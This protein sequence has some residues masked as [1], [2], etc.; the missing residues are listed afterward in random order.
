[1]TMDL[2]LID[3]HELIRSGLRRTFEAQDDMT[4][5]AELSTCAQARAAVWTGPALVTVV[6]VNLPDGSG[7][8]LVPQLRELA[9]NMGIVVL[10]MLDSDEH[11]LRAL[12]GGASAFVTKS[13]ASCE[14]VAA[15]RHA[16]ASPH[17]FTAA[18][19]AGAMRRRMAAGRGVTL[20]AR[21]RDVLDLLKLGIPVSSVAARLCISSSTAKAHISKVYEK[22]GVENRTQAIMEA[23]RLGLL[24]S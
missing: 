3:D 15:V 19:L 16:A 14:L 1:M 23:L 20:T 11:L 12:D 6:D 24:A 7:L 22:L 9:P 4:V 17:A 18:D 10:T 2:V 8:D 21:E 13:A 5:V